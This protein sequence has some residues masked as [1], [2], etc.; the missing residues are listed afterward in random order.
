VD[1]IDSCHPVNVIIVWSLLRRTVQYVMCQE[2][3]E[4]LCMQHDHDVVDIY[5]CSSSQSSYS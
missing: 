4:E 2:C 3:V 5:I 1:A